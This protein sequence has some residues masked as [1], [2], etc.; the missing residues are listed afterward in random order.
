[1]TCVL[2]LDLATITGWAL[3]KPGLVKPRANFITMPEIESTD[4]KAVPDIAMGKWMDAFIEWTIPF[5]QLEGVEHVVCELPYISDHGGAGVN[6]HEV[7]K[8]ITLTS[9][10][11]YIA[12]K[13]GARFK[14]VA[15]SKV[16][17][18]V[19]GVGSGTRKQFKG[20]CMLAVQRKGWNTTSQDIAD[21]L[22]TLD[23]Y[24]FDQRIDVPWNCN[25]APGPMFATPGVAA[26][27]K[28]EQAASAKFLNKAL[29]FD[30]GAA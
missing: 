8:N 4:E 21:A 9:A 18:H 30:K 22:C 2:S 12:F 24:C 11:S 6:I 26:P 5:A 15:R 16:V 29:S 23:W 1:M 20:W 17:K 7:E 28:T 13:I 10:A 19:A 3:Y 14:K 25:P 27:T